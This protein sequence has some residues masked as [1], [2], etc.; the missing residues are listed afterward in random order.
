VTGAAP[1]RVFT[2]EWRA[3][4]FATPASTANFEV[5]LHENSSNFEV[6]YGTLGGGGT[7]A[8]AGVQ[9]GS[10]TQF[11]QFACNTSLPNNTQ[12]NYTLGTCG[13]PSATP[14]FTSTSTPTN[15]PT[16]IAECFTDLPPGRR[17]TGTVDNRN[18]RPC[19]Q[20]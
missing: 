16:G 3:V 15:T 12:V 20:V 4:Y 9:Q 17:N 6:V 10:G 8:T 1:N 5:L 19:T 13:T 7:S 18:D 2:V 14:T 11:T